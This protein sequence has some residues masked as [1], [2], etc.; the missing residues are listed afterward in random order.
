MQDEIHEK[1]EELTNSKPVVLHDE[2]FDE[3]L[4]EVL[5]IL[6]AANFDPEDGEPLKMVDL[7][8]IFSSLNSYY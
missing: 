8:E 6:E 5:D 1:I 7:S 2:Y 4:Y 3:E